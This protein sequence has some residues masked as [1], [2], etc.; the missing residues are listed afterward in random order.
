MADWPIKARALIWLLYNSGLITAP[1]QTREEIWFSIP[2]KHEIGEFV[3]R[4]HKGKWRQTSPFEFHGTDLFLKLGRV[5][6]RKLSLYYVPATFSL[7]CADS[8][9][10]DCYAQAS[11]F[12]RRQHAR[13]TR[14]YSVL[15][16]FS[17]FRHVFDDG[18]DEYKVI[19]LNKRYL[20]FR[21]IKV[22]SE[23]QFNFPKT[24]AKRSRKCTEFHLFRGYGLIPARPKCHHHENISCISLANRLL[25]RNGPRSTCVDLGRVV[26]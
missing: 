25:T 5:T 9:V 19:M 18:T 21:V 3:K 2:T 7:V 12:I 8:F 26:K 16:L 14:P 15:V 1:F 17:C 10:Y 22:S 13:W 6:G 23:T 20:S 4:P 24:L 11:T